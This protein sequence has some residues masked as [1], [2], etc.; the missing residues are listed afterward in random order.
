MGYEEEAGGVEGWSD[1]PTWHTN[2][3]I[4]NDS[5]SYQTAWDMAK[6]AVRERAMGRFNLDKVAAFFS[7]IF[8]RQRNETKKFYEQNAADALEEQGEFEA[9]QIEGKKPPPSEFGRAGDILN[10]AMD[11]MRADMG[12]RSGWLD[13]WTEPNWKEIAESWI[14]EVTLQQKAEEAA[15]QQEHP[16]K[17]PEVAENDF[18]KQFMKDMKI[19]GSKVGGKMPVI[20]KIGFVLKGQIFARKFATPVIAR[21]FVMAAADKWGE[22]F[23]LI[24]GDA[25]GPYG[26]WETPALPSRA[27]STPRNK[28]IGQ[29]RRR[30]AGQHM[31]AGSGAAHS[32][33]S[34]Y[35]EPQ[36][37][38]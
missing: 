13:P 25:E 36:Q 8:R 32:R 16:E 10:E 15:Y 5:K 19:Q 38:L 29:S 20:N 3:L 34:G 21:K 24:A 33:A 37:E 28:G 17:T 7:Q 9:R 31:G 18:D 23:R 26:I 22:D 6:N 2:L 27:C 4:S 30:R 11:L 35:R 1:W 12:G 14:D